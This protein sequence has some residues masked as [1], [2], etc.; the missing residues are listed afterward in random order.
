MKQK[1]FT[2]EQKAF[3]LRHGDSRVPIP[4]ILRAPSKM[5]HGVHPD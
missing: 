4:D 2:E 1:P 3:A 5:T